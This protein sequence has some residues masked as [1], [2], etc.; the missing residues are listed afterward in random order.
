MIE[1]IVQIAGIG[2]CILCTGCIVWS[3]GTYVM[4][5][6]DRP[7][8]RNKKLTDNMDRLAKK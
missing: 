5:S 1:Q 7:S 8:K 6:V 4:G 2:W 3:F